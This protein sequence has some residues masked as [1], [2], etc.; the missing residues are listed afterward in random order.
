MEIFKTTEYTATQQSTI[1]HG[2]IQD[3]GLY[4]DP[5]VYNISWRYSRLRTTQ[6]PN[7]LQYI[8]EI[9][10]T[11]DYT[12]TQKSTIYHE[13]IQDYR[14]YSDATFYNASWRYSR[15]RTT[16]R[17]NSLQYVME[18][19]KTTDYTATQKSTI[20]HVIIQ[21][22]KL[23]SDA[24]FYNASWRYSRLQTTQRPNSLQYIM[25]IFK[26]TDYTATQKSTI[27]HGDIQ[28]YRLRSDPTVYNISWNYSRLQTI[29]QP[30]SLQY[31]MEIF[32]TTD[33]TAT[34]HSTMH[35]GDIQDYG[36]YSDATFY[37]AS[38]RYSR[39]QTIQQP[40]SLQY[41]M[42]IF[43]TTDYTAT[44]QSTIYHGDIQDYRIY[45]DPKVYNISWRYSRLQTTQRPNSLQYIM[46]LFKTTDYTATQQS[47][48][49]HGIIQDYRLYSD[50]TV[51]NISWRY[52]RLRTIQRRNILQCIMEIFKTTDY[53]ATQQS[54]IYHGDIQDYRLYSNPTVYNISWRYSRLQ[55]IQQPNSL[56]YI[57]EIFKT[58]DYTATQQSTIYHGDIQ[59]YRLRSEST[60]YNISWRYSR[61]QTIQ[62]PNSLQYIM[63]IFNTTDYT[64]TQHST[65][66]HGDIQDYRLRSDPTV[67]NISWRYSRL[68]TIQRPK[69]LQYI[70]EIFKT[71]DYAANQQ[72]TIYHGDI[73]DYRLYS[74]PTVYNISWRYSIL[75]TIQRTNSLQY[76][77]EIFKTTDY[78]A[79]QQSTIYHG[80]I[81]D[82][83]LYS[84]PIVY[85]ISWRYS[86]LQTIQQ[87]NSLQY[88]MELFK[89]TDYTATQQST[90]YHGDIQDYRL[91]SDSTV[92]NISWNYSRLQTIQR[93]NSLQYIM[94]IFKTTDYTATQQSTIYHGDIQDYRPYSDPK[95][96]NISWRYSRLQTIQRPNILQYIMEI[97]NTTDYTATQQSTIYH[98][99]I[100]YYRLYSDATFYNASWR[101]SRLRT[102]QRPNSLQYIMEIF[103]TTD[104]TSTQKSTIYHGDIQD[105]RLRSDPTVYNISWRY[106][107]LQTIQQPNSL[108]YIMELFKT[109]DYTPTQ[110]LTIYHGDIQDYRLY[111][112][113]TVYNISWRYSRLQ[114]IQRPNSLQYIMEIFKTTDYTATQ[115]STIYHGVIQDYRLYTDPT[116]YNISWRYS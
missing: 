103:K 106:S 92:Y 12:A 59:D 40:N 29:Q 55:T 45:R 49:Y 1:Y 109:T 80:I 32:K 24:T 14:L 66:H 5:T 25:E 18:I 88:I 101:Y 114:T 68:Q 115:Q 42:E 78:T 21:D 64:A 53:T 71:T 105:Y 44:Q 4:S 11:T 27:Y 52:S 63:E 37:N 97:F 60:V 89:T 54:T 50:P 30:N 100:Q 62:Q 111:S 70:M 10:K 51:Y 26:T 58:T 22:Y 83:R 7:S 98:A 17:P 85:N 9:F 38:W 75:Q 33:Y 13:I 108:Q 113:P 72:S 61:L 107:R 16:Q 112:N 82:Y 34:Q 93:P 3:Y 81:Q 41:I 46:E 104:Y 2:D 84:D 35:H 15:L 47:T 76:I 91:Y 86:R 95:V 6:R 65:M 19:F 73:Q 23:Y 110:Q 77:M 87:P 20:Y 8:M 31:I 69:S 43:K 36:L 48:I 39:L 116:A 94:E 28:D 79:T 67:Y 99:D 90:I 96:Y 57:M 102:T 74:N 56:Q